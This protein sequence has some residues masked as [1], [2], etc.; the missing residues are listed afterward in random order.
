M[1]GWLE[2][3]PESLAR[4]ITAPQSVKP[5]AKMPGIA[6]AGG[7]FPPTNLSQEQARAGAEYL[8][9]LGRAPEGGR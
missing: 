3:S 7:N 2:N 4:W 9:S 1:A 8:S 6:E 5:G